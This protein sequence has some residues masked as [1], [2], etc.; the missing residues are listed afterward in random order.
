MIINDKLRRFIGVPA[1]GGL[2]FICFNELSG[3]GAL[4][5]LSAIRSAENQHII[6]AEALKIYREQHE[7][8]HLKLLARL[9]DGSVMYVGPQIPHF[10]I[11][12]GEKLAVYLYEK[13]H[14]LR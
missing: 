2:L 1:V 8:S 9:P 6:P 12:S 14:G 7:E 13:Y 4:N 5:W 10:I 11:E 3:G